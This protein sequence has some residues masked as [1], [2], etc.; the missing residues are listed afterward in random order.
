MKLR[1]SIACASILAGVLMLALPASASDALALF[2]QARALIEQGRWADALPLLIESHR[3][4]PGA[5]GILLNLADTYK[6]VGKTAS[7]WSKYRAGEFIAKRNHDDGREQ[8]ARQ[9]AA[10]LEP[11]LSRL[12]INA[13]ATPGLVVRRDDEEVGK[14]ALGI[15]L[16]VDPG[17]HKIEASAPGF[18]VWTTT[19]RIGAERDNQTVEV[20]LLQKSAGGN[21]AGA[22]PW[23]ARRI[24]GLGVGIGGLVGLAVGTAF[25]VQAISK[26]NA[27]NADGHCD[28][29]D[30]CDPA[31]KALRADSIHAG[32]IST[33]LFVA[34]GV[35]VAGGIVLVVTAPSGGKPVAG[36]TPSAVVRCGPGS[37][38]L[39]GRW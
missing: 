7:A 20:P 24:A 9:E 34:G 1:S 10:A 11:R 12:R 29:A 39:T 37:L 2:T 30:L 36:A 23:G 6:H 8:Y 22:T 4:E 16:P 31:G 14:G 15:S 35:L 5:L 3:Q 13:A 19:V 26:K 17:D 27:S 28:A 18:A 33:G 32:N 25:G 21:A 38:A